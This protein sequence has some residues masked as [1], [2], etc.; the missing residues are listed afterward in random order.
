[1][2]EIFLI[3]TFPVLFSVGLLAG[4]FI[5][6]S[7]V[8]TEVKTE[9]VRG[10]AVTGSVSPTQFEAVNEDRPDVVYR[11]TGSVK[12]VN[13]P[14]DTAAIIADWETKRTYRLTA[15]DNE[16]GKL[17]LFPVIQ[18]N[19]LSALDYSFTPVIERQMAYRTRV[20]QPFVS[21]SWS[22]IGYTGAGGGVFY[23]N[24]GFEYQYLKGLR[25]GDKGHLLGVKWRF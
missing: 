1:M 4:F 9:Y 22:S 15:F 20:W 25:N 3:L 24:I 5:G 19:R 21:A 2:K 23:H 6:K 8:D 7:T 14:A 12:Y 18:F 17:E 10:E 13:L 11:D 16:K